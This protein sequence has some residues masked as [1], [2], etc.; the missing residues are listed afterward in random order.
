MLIFL[1]Q[2][3]A[4][5]H[6]TWRTFVQCPVYSTVQTERTEKIMPPRNRILIVQRQRIIQALEDVSE[7]YLTVAVTIGV[8]RS[9]ARSIVARYLR[10]GRSRRD[11]KEEQSCPSRWW[12][13][14]LP[15][16]HYQRKLPGN[17]STDKSRVE[18]ASC[19]KTGNP[20][21]HSSKNTC[22]P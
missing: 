10:E 12:N 8:D 2:S 11:H 3:F 5:R 20:W 4:E 6:I 17:T 7:D 1:A 19:T 14:E 9:T 22:K 16:W 15:E 18:A 13:E 21:P